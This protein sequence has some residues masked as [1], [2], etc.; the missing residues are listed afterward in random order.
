MGSVTQAVFIGGGDSE[1]AS[2]GG[3][4]QVCA[5]VGKL[6]LCQASVVALGYLPRSLSHVDSDLQDVFLSVQLLAT[7]LQARNKAAQGV[8]AEFVERRDS[9]EWIET[10]MLGLGLPLDLPLESHVPP[11]Y[12]VCA[13]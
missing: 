12:D 8:V 5:A 9:A 3:L 1:H 11:S 10:A 6:W 4:E 7:W 13:G 2:G